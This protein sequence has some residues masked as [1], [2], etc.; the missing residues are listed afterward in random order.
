MENPD[1]PSYS[2]MRTPKLRKDCIGKKGSDR[3]VGNQLKT[4]GGKGRNYFPTA[5]VVI[6][7][8]LRSQQ[9]FLEVQC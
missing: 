7:I 4:K 3:G 9:I 1:G 2:K 5:H 8:S 6:K